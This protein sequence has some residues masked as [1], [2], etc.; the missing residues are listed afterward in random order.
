MKNRGLNTADLRWTRTLHSPDTLGDD[1]G[2]IGASVGPRTGPNK[3]S[4]GDKEDYV[5][6]RLLAAW[7]LSEQLRFPVEIHAERDRDNCPDFVLV[8]PDGG[9]LGVEVTEAGEEQYQRWLT[10]TE[11][12]TEPEGVVHVPFEAST[13]RTVEELV[14]A[15]SKKVQKYD[16]G[17][18]RGPTACQ[19]IVYDNTSWGGFLDKP[20]LI[21]GVRAHSNLAGRFNQVHLVFGE[22]VVLDVWGD[23]KSVDVSRAYEIDYPRWISSQVEN[24]REFSAGKL[25]AKNIA[26]ELQDLGKTERRALASYT[27]NLLLHL[28]KYEFQSKK[29]G[30][31]W[32]AS[33]NSARAEIE[34]ILTESPSL[35]QEFAA[36]INRQYPRARQQASAE[37]ALLP[38]RFP[39]SCPYSP[40]QLLDDEY[41]P[42]EM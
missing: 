36:Q 21:D 17:S 23:I 33:I 37:T 27:R 2:S 26:E 39:Q 40:E 35:R 19:L 7:R 28:L 11:D 1:L 6:R 41:L 8:W 15:V 20:E 29:R 3:R 25:D 31:S 30:S 32:K 42:G 10:E 14:R 34:E 18:Y 13:S 22:R 12:R 4:K 16:Q 5:L 38:E 9:T 24:L